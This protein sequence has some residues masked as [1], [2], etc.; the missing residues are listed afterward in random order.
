MEFCQCSAQN[1]SKI[2]FRDRTCTNIYIYYLDVTV[3]DSDLIDV[4]PI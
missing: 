4:K 3:N 2:I 1:Y